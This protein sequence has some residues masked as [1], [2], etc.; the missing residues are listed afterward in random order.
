MSHN[1]PPIS[2]PFSKEKHQILLKLGSFCHNL[3]KIH[4]NLCNL[5]SF[6]SDENPPITL[7]NFVKIAYQKAGT[8]IGISY[9]CETPEEFSVHRD[10]FGANSAHYHFKELILQQH[11]RVQGITPNKKLFAMLRNKKPWRYNTFTLCVTA[12]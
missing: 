4:P 10:C 8:Y 2:I 7:P 1:Y 6:I 11:V 5:G 9:Q 12:K 3:L